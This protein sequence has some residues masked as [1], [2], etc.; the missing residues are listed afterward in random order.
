ME[1]LIT[2]CVTRMIS[3]GIIDEQRRPL[4]VYGLDLL[5]S[6]MINLLS[7]LGLGFILGK[8]IQTCCLLLCSIPLQSFGGGYHCKTHLRCWL[9]MIIEY[10]VAVYPLAALP[11]QILWIGSIIAACY[12]IKFAPIENTKAPFGEV[13]RKKMRSIVIVVLFIDMLQAII[14]YICHAPLMKIFPIAITLSGLSILC[15]KGKQKYNN[16]IN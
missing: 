4:I 15:A 16:R 14:A 11:V 10:L 9:L 2:G 1:Q 12:V 6:S 13:F 5:F 7:L 8:G 3:Y